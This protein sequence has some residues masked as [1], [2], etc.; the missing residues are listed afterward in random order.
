MAAWVTVIAISVIEVK[1]VKSGLWRTVIGLILNL[2]ILIV[3]IA[4]EEW[5]NEIAK[6]VYI[7]SLLYLV[8]AFKS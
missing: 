1:W 3:W 7:V 5:K 2:G 6:A 8:L 4:G